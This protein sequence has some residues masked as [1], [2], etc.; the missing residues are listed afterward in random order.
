MIRRLKSLV[1]LRWLSPAVVLAIV[2]TLIVWSL[3]QAAL[4]LAI[5]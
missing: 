4:W 1:S 3:V 5:R 2:A